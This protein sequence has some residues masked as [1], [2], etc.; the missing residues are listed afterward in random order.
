MKWSQSRTNVNQIT[1]LL[2]YLLFRLF[3]Y[4]NNVSSGYANTQMFAPVH[5]Q[6]LLLFFFICYCLLIHITQEGFSEKWHV[7]EK[8]HL[9]SITLLYRKGLHRR[10]LYSKKVVIEP[11]TNMFL[12]G[13]KLTIFVWRKIFFK[14]WILICRIS[15]SQSAHA[16]KRIFLV[17]VLFCFCFVY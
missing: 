8:N 3:Y 16:A 15:S 12:F 9:D 5:S 1:N 10:W 2:T 11:E 4:P 14:K 17:D 7:F 6:G 13:K